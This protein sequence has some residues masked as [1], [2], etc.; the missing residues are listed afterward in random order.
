VAD[1]SLEGGRLRIG[2]ALLVYLEHAYAPAGPMG[3][4]AVP[5]P[6]GVAPAA[7]SAP[8]VVVAA[9]AAGEAIWLG[10][11]AVDPARPVPVR[12]RMAGFDTV[13][14]TCPP[15]TRLVG[16][17][18]GEGVQP[19]GTTTSESSGG[20][21]L[22][23]LELTAWTPAATTVAIQLVRPERFAA[24]TGVVPKPIDP[25]SAYGGWRLP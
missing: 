23:A 25:D 17:P 20:E 11:Q 24:L 22:E 6:H 21:L 9:V 10:F 5:R 14:L 1:L 16:M 4:G 13:N 2:N 3:P 19:F 12:I 8:G 18:H 15:D 7:V